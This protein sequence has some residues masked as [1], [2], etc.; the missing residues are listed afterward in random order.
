MSTPAVAA[1]PWGLVL[2]G[3]QARRMGGG[4]KALLPFHGRPLLTWA[5]QALSPH[6]DRVILSANDAEPFAPFGLE[7]VPDALPSHGPLGG[8]HAGLRAAGGAPLLVLACDLPLLEAHDLDPLVREGSRADVVIYR[9]ERGI[10][11]LV[12]WYGPAA[13]PAIE[14]Q[15]AQGVRRIRVFYDQVR[16]TTLPWVGDLDRLANVNTP[17]DLARLER[18]AMRLDQA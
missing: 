1:R 16:T 3:G 7:V 10:E 11:P 2:A 18:A 4:L 13:L 14:R 15:L 12:G 6:C 8:I 5:L 9:H 17:E